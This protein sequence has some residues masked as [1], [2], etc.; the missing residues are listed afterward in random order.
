MLYILLYI[1]EVII[2]NKNEKPVDYVWPPFI[3]LM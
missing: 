3:V 1:R 2:A